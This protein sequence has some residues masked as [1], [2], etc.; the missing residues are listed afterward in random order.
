M[1]IILAICI[2]VAFQVGRYVRKGRERER[3]T[4]ILMSLDIPRHEYVNA[5]RLIFDDTIFPE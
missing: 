3:I 2:P 1:N 5:G 4:R